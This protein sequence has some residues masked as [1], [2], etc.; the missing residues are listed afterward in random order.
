MGSSGGMKGNFALKENFVYVNLI[1]MNQ[2]EVY[3]SA[4]HTLFDEE[5]N[6]IEKTK[7]FVEDST[8]AFIDFAK[9][10]S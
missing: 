1:T 3:I 10:H 6:L 9:K 8:R 4:V 5:G 7:T 2:P